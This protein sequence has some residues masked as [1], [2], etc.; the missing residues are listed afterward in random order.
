MNFSRLRYVTEININYAQLLAYMWTIVIW[1][2]IKIR[3]D[4][5]N[6]VSRDVNFDKKRQYPF[7]KKRKEIAA[8]LLVK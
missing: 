2:I 3:V 4:L 6:C 5:Y 7:K 8:S 1:M